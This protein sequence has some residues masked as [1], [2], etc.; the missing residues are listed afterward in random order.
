ML[1][2]EGRSLCIIEALN[3]P[4]VEYRAD[5]PNFRDRER[6]MHGGDI[7]RHFKDKTSTGNT[8]WQAVLA[9]HQRKARRGSP[10]TGQS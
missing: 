1:Y 3:F 7:K 4:A 8:S 10:T 5:I 9:E 2:W 6:S